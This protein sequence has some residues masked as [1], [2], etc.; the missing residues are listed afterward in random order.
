[1]LKW[2]IRENYV[3][4]GV[5]GKEPTGQCKSW[6]LKCALINMTKKTRFGL[7]LHLFA[8]CTS[9]MKQSCCDGRVPLRTNKSNR[10]YF[11][12]YVIGPYN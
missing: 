1:M 9:S 8:V 6:P 11:K 4:S 5:S 10:Q 3:H 2:S 12:Y 7:M